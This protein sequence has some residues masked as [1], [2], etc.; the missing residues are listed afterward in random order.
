VTDA[1][2]TLKMSR[3]TIYTYLDRLEDDGRIRR[4]G[5]GVEVLEG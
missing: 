1:A 2:R 3:Q 4:N 5:H